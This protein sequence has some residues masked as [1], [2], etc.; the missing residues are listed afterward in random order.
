V[1]CG[2]AAAVEES[3]IEGAS[4][5]DADAAAGAAASSTPRQNVASVIRQAR[6]LLDPGV[7]PLL[8]GATVRRTPDEVIAPGLTRP[9]PAAIVLTE[10]GYPFLRPG[11]K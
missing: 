4:T 5:D 10:C 11:A 8:A 6:R 3:V 2:T 9:S 1:T 7:P